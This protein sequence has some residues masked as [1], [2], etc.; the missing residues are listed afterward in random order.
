MYNLILTRAVWLIYVDTCFFCLRWM[1]ILI[2]VSSMLENTWFYTQI[3]A[4]YWFAYYENVLKLKEV[5]GKRLC[6]RHTSYLFFLCFIMHDYEVD[7][8]RLKGFTLKMQAAIPPD[9]TSTIHHIHVYIIHNINPFGCEI[10]RYTLILWCWAQ[11]NLSV[12]NTAYFYQY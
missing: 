2:V 7:Y 11:Y 3:L 6:L 10:D 5:H 4:V 9:I 8:S 12:I 1:C